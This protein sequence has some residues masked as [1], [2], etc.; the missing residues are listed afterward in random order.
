[1]GVQGWVGVR[2]FSWGLWSKKFEKYF[3]W[4]LHS[5]NIPFLKYHSLIAT[6]Y[7][8]CSFSTLPTPTVAALQF[9]CGPLAQQL[10]NLRTGIMPHYK[11]PTPSQS[12]LTHT[13]THYHTAHTYKLSSPHGVCVFLLTLEWK[14]TQKVSF[15]IWADMGQNRHH[16]W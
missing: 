8:I 1:M 5:Q 2:F 13:H 7:Y 9:P 12:P 16:M 3:P 4:L 15:H 11:S 6:N 10:R 14:L